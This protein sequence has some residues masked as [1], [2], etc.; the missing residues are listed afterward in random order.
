VDDIDATQHKD[1]IYANILAALQ[2]R[3]PDEFK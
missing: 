1:T 2:R 3:R